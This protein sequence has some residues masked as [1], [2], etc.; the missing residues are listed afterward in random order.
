MG[1]EGGRARGQGR[2][3]GDPRAD[4]A[5]ARPTPR[6]PSS[7]ASDS[8]WTAT[9]GPWPTTTRCARA[10]YARNTR[11]DRI[12]GDL[13]DAHRA[14]HDLLWTLGDL[15]ADLRHRIEGQTFW[16]DTGEAG[17]QLV[18]AAA[19]P[20]GSF[21][22]VHLLG[23]VDGE[24]PRRQ[25][26]NIFYS[27]ALLTALGWPAD[28]PDPLAPARAT[29]VDLLQSA[30]AHAS[31]S[32]FSLEDDALVEPSSLLDDIGRAGLTPIALDIPDVRVFQDEA[33]ALAGS[34]SNDAD[35]WLADALSG[36]TR[37]WAALRASRLPATL[38]RFHGAAGP[39]RPRARS[40]SALELYAQC[41]FKFYARYVLRLA[42]ERDDDEALSPLERGRMHHELFEAIFAAWQSRGHGGITPERLDEA[43]TLALATMETHLSRLSP[44]DA[45]LERT[46]LVGSPVA[47]GLIDVV[48]RLEA[49]RPTEVVERRLEHA[50]DGVYQFAG[51]D[52]PRAIEVRGIADRIDLLKDGT[53]RVFD[54]KA[55]RPGSTLQIALYATCVRQKLRG[56]RGRDWQL[57]EAA[58][59][60]F[61]GDKTVVPLATR[62]ADNDQALADAEREVVEITDAIAEGRFLRAPASGPCARAVR[63]RPCAAR[64]TWMPTNPRLPFDDAPA[65][66]AFG[67]GDAALRDPGTSAPGGSATLLP[68]AADRADAVDPRL[69]IVLEASA[70]TGKTRVLVDRYVNLVRA[71]VEPRHI[72]AITFTRKAAAEMRERIL[73]TLRRAAEQG[74]IDPRRW[75]LL[76]EHLS[77]VAISTIDAF[78]LSLLR[79]FPLEAGLDPGFG[80]ADETE[81]LRLTDEALDRALRICRAVA[82]EDPAVAMVFAEL[83]DLQLRAGLAGLLD[84]R[85]VAGPILDRAVRPTPRELTPERVAADAIARLVATLGGV[86]GGL[87]RFLA[88]G[89]VRHPRYR[90]FAED[91]RKAVAMPVRTAECETRKPRCDCWSTASTSISSRRTDRPA[92]NGPR[93]RSTTRWTAGRSRR[94]EPL[95]RR[96]PIGWATTCAPS[97]AT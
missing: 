2:R 95:P 18:D 25:R 21:D 1:R 3:R 46:R 68:D 13:A 90:L 45:A 30:D 50:I 42:E 34:H 10:C 11:S 82:R 87:A 43:R 60:A 93:T 59:V 33:L 48:L 53:F 52:G 69:N 66:P 78:C 12:I 76:R 28:Q 70:G 89:P 31:V 17:V 47:P 63:L 19:A 94:I 15:A 80:M 96:W 86:E 5:F 16:P 83:G 36:E 91:V 67:A 4:A 24:W 75:T 57:A 9:S 65:P 73:A 37:Q 54:Y 26:R 88:T 77:D 22:A 51:P 79:E 35:A 74:G 61:R 38:P 20:F 72:L 8:F 56:Y 49:E 39:Q 6:A 32:T 23:L 62:P 41:P 84:R 71:G 7:S 92:R 44:V 40:V 81:A 14:H 58:Y 97:G 85:L 27:P 29:F 55:S 64:T